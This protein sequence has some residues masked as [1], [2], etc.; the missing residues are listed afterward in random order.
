MWGARARGLRGEPDRQREREEERRGGRGWLMLVS[1]TIT[2]CLFRGGCTDPVISRAGLAADVGVPL[3]VDIRIIKKATP[4]RS[5]PGAERDIWDAPTNID[6]DLDG[7]PR[8]LAGTAPRVLRPA[9]NPALGVS[10]FT[11]RSTGSSLFCPPRR[12]DE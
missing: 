11:G 6:V 4:F 3:S 9:P 7:C 12:A 8:K 1:P 10:R 5:F 2:Y